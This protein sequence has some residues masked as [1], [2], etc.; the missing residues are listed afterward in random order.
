MRTQHAG[1]LEAVNV[2]AEVLPDDP[3][4]QVARTIDV[5]R[6]L[7]LEDARSALVRDIARQFP[8]GERG[9]AEAAF[10][11]VRGLVRFQRDAQLVPDVPFAPDIIEVLIRPA[12]LLAMD[13]PRGDCDDF[14]MAL[15]SL[16]VARGIR[17]SFA[18]VAADPRDPGRYSHVYVVAHL[19]GGDLALDA[20][21]GRRPGWEV[22]N[23]YGKRRLWRV[24]Q[25]TTALGFVS[26]ATQGDPAWLQLAKQ[27][28]EIVKGRVGIQKNTT[29]VD[30]KGNVIARGTD[31]MAPTGVPTRY[32]ADIRTKH[33]SDFMSSAGWILAAGAVMVFLVVIVMAAKGGKR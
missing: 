26:A 15:A 16:L 5:M 6:Q 19:A 22:R 13:A 28:I 7:A 14:C 30:E 23:A 18:T 10:W 11:F 8:A 9:C 4:R 17:C 1:W 32:T 3:D 31:T 33:E 24:D 29:I 21:H 12:D 25:V 20:S 2:D 27:G